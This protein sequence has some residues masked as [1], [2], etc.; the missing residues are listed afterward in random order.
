MTINLAVAILVSGCA[1]MGH[2]GFTHLALPLDDEVEIFRTA[3]IFWTGIAQGDTATVRQ[4]TTGDEAPNW[5][6]KWENAYPGF[7]H[8]TAGQLTMLGGQ[9]LPIEGPQMADSTGALLSIEVPWISC[10]APYHDGRNDQYRIV[11]VHDSTMWL[12]KNVETGIC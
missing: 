8:S 1:Q 3:E 12:I 4:V 9:Y 10:K 2:A 5:A 11:A 7:F 6:I